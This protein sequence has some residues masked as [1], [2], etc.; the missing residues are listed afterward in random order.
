MGINSCGLKGRDSCAL[1]G[2]MHRRREYS[3]TQAIGLGCETDI[4]PRA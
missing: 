2:P 4:T 1:L 3:I